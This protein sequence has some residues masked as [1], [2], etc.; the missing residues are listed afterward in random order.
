MRKIEARLRLAAQTGYNHKECV[1]NNTISGAGRIAIAYGKSEQTQAEWLPAIFRFDKMEFRS[2]RK[3]TEKQKNALRMRCHSAEFETKAA[4]LRGPAR[5]MNEWA[6]IVYPKS[7]AWELLADKSYLMPIEA[8]IALDIPTSDYSEAGFV[9]SVFDK[10]FVQKWHGKRKTLQIGE[11]TYTSWD[12]TG[13]RFVW[14][15]SRPIKGKQ[16]PCFHIE[17]R[18]RTASALSA[19]GI[20][21]MGCLRDFDHVAFWQKHLNLY[22]VNVSKLGK[23]HCKRCPDQPVPSAHSMYDAYS[24]IGRI[25]AHVHSERPASADRWK[26]KSGNVHELEEWR[27]RR[28]LQHLVDGYGLDSGVLEKIP[29]SISTGF[30]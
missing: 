9:V 2:K 6:R 10:H 26:D 18:V 15:G 28:L 14:Y 20:E 3:L 30:M 7:G 23:L 24:G 11:G 21:T 1:V 5:G 27:R 12:T 17:C 16:Q 22:S 13:R 25:L 29:I 4:P 8:E 19:I